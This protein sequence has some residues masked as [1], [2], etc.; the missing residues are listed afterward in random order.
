[1]S[2]GWQTSAPTLPSGA[3]WG[4]WKTGNA[5]TSNTYYNFRVSARIARGAQNTIWLQIR[6]Q[7]YGRDYSTAGSATISLRAEARLADEDYSHSSSGDYKSGY[8]EWSTVKTW[9]Y[10]NDEAYFGDTAYARVYWTSSH[11][12]GAQ[13][14][15][16]PDYATT[17]AIS[18]DG[19]GQT[20]GD[21]EDETKIWNHN[22]TIATNTYEKGGYIFDHWNTQ[23]DDSGTSYNEGASYNINTALNLYAIWTYSGLPFIIGNPLVV[24]RSI[25]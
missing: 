14:F 15:A 4:D 17:L 2:S 9:Y 16:T 24:I 20:S 18:Y 5:N 19:N 25:T 6:I 7:T 21:M 22:Y 10:Y 23:P 3:S 13:S 1:M 11:I 8:G 12:T